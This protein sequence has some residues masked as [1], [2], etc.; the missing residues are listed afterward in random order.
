MKTKTV[1]ESANTITEGIINMILGEGFSARRIN[2]TGIYK[3]ELMTFVKSGME[4]G[5]SDIIC[6]IA[7]MYVGVEVKFK[8]DKMRPGQEDFQKEVERAGG[9]YVVIKTWEQADNWWKLFN[10]QYWERIAAHRKAF[11]STYIDKA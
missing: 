5:F 7:G 1:I 11:E 3:P 4:P 10:F 9:I 8:R 6:C 2:V